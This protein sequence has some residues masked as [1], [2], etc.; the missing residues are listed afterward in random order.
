MKMTCKIRWTALSAIVCTGTAVLAATGPKKVK[1]DKVP[2]EYKHPIASI[3]WEKPTIDAV[4]NEAEWQGAFSQ[5]ALRTVHGTISTRQ[6][7]F[8]MMWDEENIYVAMRDSLRKGE[9]L[10]NAL[11]ERGRETN[12]VFDDSYEIWISIATTCS[13]FFA[14]D[15]ASKQRSRRACG[16]VILPSQAKQ[17]GILKGQHPP[18]P[19]HLSDAHRRW[20]RGLVLLEKAVPAAT[21]VPPAPALRPVRTPVSKL[22]RLWPYSLRLCSPPEPFL[23]LQRSLWRQG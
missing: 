9:R 17:L 20:S 2:E 13:T 10:L 22:S 6:A 8:W 19:G 18:C 11:R 23:P 4:V 21:P 12:V 15:S 1:L 5:Q 7:R 16:S 14:N 3:P